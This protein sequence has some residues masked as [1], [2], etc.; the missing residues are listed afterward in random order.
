M[1]CRCES[2]DTP[3]STILVGDRAFRLRYRKPILRQLR[4]KIPFH[5]KLVVMPAQGLQHVLGII[6]AVESE[7]MFADAGVTLEY[8]RDNV[9]RCERQ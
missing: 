7:A 6:P 3:F 5:E 4:A 2:R 9:L 8:F 1:F